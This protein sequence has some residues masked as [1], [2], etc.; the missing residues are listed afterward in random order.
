MRVKLL[1]YIRS[2][3]SVILYILFGVLTTAV[4]Y[5]IYLPLYNYTSIPAFACNM[6]AWVFAVVIAFL[7]N[8]PLVFRS[9]DWSLKTTVSE[10]AKFMGLRIFSGGLETLLIFVMVDICNGDGNFWK[11]FTSVLV[12]ILNY[13]ASKFIVFKKS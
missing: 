7:T 4:N 3:R 10:F 6:V 11:V 12:I 9:M 8:K 13:F 1:S 5:A 2:K